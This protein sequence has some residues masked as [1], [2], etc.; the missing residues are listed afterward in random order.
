METQDIFIEPESKIERIKT[1]SILCSKTE[2]QQGL[3]MGV[4]LLQPNDKRHCLITKHDL[5][6]KLREVAK[7]RDCS[8]AQIVNEILKETGTNFQATIYD[9]SYERV[10]NSVVLKLDLGLLQTA[11]NEAKRLNMGINAYFTYI[12]EH[13]FNQKNKEL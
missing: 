1:Y 8:I 3:Y 13:Y 7:K 11:K 12:I 9:L 4:S 5:I 6:M 10:F 2:W